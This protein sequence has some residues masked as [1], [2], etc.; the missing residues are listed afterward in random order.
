MLFWGE[1]S[2]CYYLKQNFA[3]HLRT[4]FVL[5]Y[6]LRGS[7]HYNVWISSVFDGFFSK[8]ASGPPFPKNISSIL[9]FKQG[10]DGCKNRLQPFDPLPPQRRRRRVIVI[11]VVVGVL[12]EGSFRSQT[13]DNM[14]R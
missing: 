8:A 3:L 4:S 7:G 9:F 12:V 10:R 5:P 6:A 11:V 14:D 1:E 2:P 13:S